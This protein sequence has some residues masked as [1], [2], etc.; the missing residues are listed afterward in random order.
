MNRG[1][2]LGGLILALGS[3]SPAGAQTGEWRAA[4]PTRV[5]A[6]ALGELKPVPSVSL[7]KPVPLADDAARTPPAAGLRQTSY[8]ASAGL[9]TTV[10]GLA[11]LPEW[12]DDEDKATEPQGTEFAVERRLPRLPRLVEPAADIA[13]AT[14]E[15]A[16][17]EGDKKSGGL[18]PAFLPLFHTADAPATAGAADEAVLR[19]RFYV[20]GEYLLWWTKE[21][22]VPVLAATSNTTDTGF[23]GRP[24]TQVLFGNSGLNGDARS[25]FRITGGWWLDLCKEEAIEF[26]GFY[27]APDTAKFNVS[28]AT[29]PL[30]ARPF[31]NLNQGREFSQITAFPGLATGRLLID[32]PSKF[33]GAEAN[34]KC[35]V[36]CGCNYRVDLFGGF[37]YLDLEES[38]DVTEDVLGLPASAPIFANQRIKVNDFFS[39]R[40]QF[41][42]GQLGVHAEWDRGP[43]SV[44]L[45]GKLALGD[46]HQDILIDGS[47][48][49]VAPDGT[50][51]NFK[52]SLLALPTNIGRYHRDKFSV[53]PELGLNVGY[54]LT[55][56]LRAYVGYNVLYWNNVAR[57]GGQ[58]DRVIDITNIPNFPV[59]GTVATGQNRPAPTLASTDFWAQGIN[60]GLEF[61]Y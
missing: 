43:W 54:Q 12:T 4:S 3:V 1:V 19:P 60:V 15:T 18:L 37:R 7:G 53:V 58:I 24:S 25:G 26:S 28:S 17:D 46:T 47:Q 50:V 33:W 61:R 34:L 36:C 5:P 23:L 13:L 41:Y 45:R 51:Q 59:P 52:G 11:P 57:P 16:T 29:T 20:N 55:S 39:T 10:R 8:G 48:R 56:H 31:F 6:T 27:L 22:K 14:H 21:D 38:I 2:W 32:A 42:G 30:I 35:N 49:F 9:P 44:D 40:D